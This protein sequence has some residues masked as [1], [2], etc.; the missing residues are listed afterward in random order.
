MLPRPCPSGTKIDATTGTVKVTNVRD[1]SGK[2]Q[3][4]TFWGGAFA[5]RQTRTK[6]PATVLSLTASLSCAKSARSLSSV[7][8]KAPRARQLWGRDNNGRFVTRGRSAVAT[9]RGTVWLVRDTCAGTL[10]K[11]TRGQV[12]VF[13]LVRKRTVLV[14]AGHSYL[15]RTL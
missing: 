8:A 9:V 10:V 2:L 7:A 11:V 14:R 6:K 3:T 1:R 4:G 13:D 5:V 12:S 15:A